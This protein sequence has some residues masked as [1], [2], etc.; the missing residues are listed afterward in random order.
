MNDLSDELGLVRSWI[1]DGLA[2]F[3]VYLPSLLS[4]LVIVVLGWWVARTLRGTAKRLFGWAN[5]RLDRVFKRGHLASVRVR[6]QM[7]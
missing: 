6:H 4:A 7:I 5:R 2:A 3:I 1:E